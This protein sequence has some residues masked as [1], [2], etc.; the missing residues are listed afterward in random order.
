MMNSSLLSRTWIFL[1]AAGA[2]ALLDG[3]LA[4]L[5]PSY[6]WVAIVAGHGLVLAGFLG[7]AHYL[8]K[9]EQLLVKA[10]SICVAAAKGDL[11]ARVLEPPEPGTLGLIQRGIN[12]MLDIADAFVREA[13]GS[14][15][16]VSNGKYFRKV[17]ERGLPGAFGNA[18]RVLNRASSGM[19]QKVG[20]F[21]AFADNNV[22]A[23]V[24][25]VATAA[26]DMHQGAETMSQASGTLSGRATSAA[27]ATEESAVSVQTV[28]AAAEELTASV[29]EISRQVT[30]SSEIARNAVHRVEETNTTVKSLADVGKKVGEVVQLIND[31]ASQTNLL[32]LNATIEAARAGEAGKGFAVVATEVKALASQTS[33]A[34]VEI[35]EQVQAIQSISTETVDAMEK[36]GGV[37]REMNEIAGTIAAAVQEQGAATQEIARNIQQAAEGTREVSSNIIGVMQHATDSGTHSQQL[38][39]RASDL[40]TQAEGLN[41]EVKIFLVKLRAL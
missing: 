10:A 13:S 21:V 31:I 35:G 5:L 36:I 14:M 4:L 8:R 32:A 19:E 6:G 29:D 26:S 38:L 37:I 7:A 18:A 23:I 24:E 15:R 39:A 1:A 22:R 27:A 2:L 25:N 17:L 30:H 9:T 41:E 3:A 33:K 40:S 34:T 12:D 11:E 20:E 28:A 16:Y